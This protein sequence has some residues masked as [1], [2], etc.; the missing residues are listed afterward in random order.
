M[1][2]LPIN[3]E[4]DFSLQNLPYGVF[5]PGPG[6]A[7]R[8]GVAVGNKVMDLS[9]LAEE[10]VFGDSDNYVSCFS[11][12]YLN[13]FMAMGKSA[14]VSVRKTLQKLLSEDIAELRDN[15]ELKAKVF[16]SL[17]SVTMELPAKIGDY[18]DF[19]SSRE[20]A[21][22]V[23][24]MFRGK[25]N[26]LQPNWLHLPV[27]YHGRASSVVVSGTSIRRPC[28]QLQ[29]NMK[30]PKEGSKYGVSERLDIELE[31]G[32]LIGPGNELGTP[33][34]I[35][36]AEDHIFGFV[37]LN[38]W[39]ARDIQK[40]EYV[41]L[42]PFGAKNFGTTIS[43]WVV[44]PMALEPFKCKTSAGVQN[45][46][47]PLPYLVEPDYRSYDI[48]LRVTIQADDIP[49]PVQVSRSNFKNMYWTHRQQLV[50]HT[51]TGCNMKPG[52]LLGS[53][54][55]SG[56]TEDSYGSFLELSWNKQ[57]QV[58]CGESAT[59]YFLEDGDVISITGTCYGD[60]YRIGFGDCIGKILPAQSKYI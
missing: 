45:D 50:H 12:P 40:W 3:P 47:E 57:K 22:N 59:R 51:V 4:S 55:I 11:K 15:E 1:S 30:D 39:S 33:I 38:D 36:D 23:G 17:D 53:G 52:D 14:W 29:K 19:Y 37:L 48:D 54:T 49:K 21:T 7:A 27:G 16:H 34:D 32:V 58:Q 35:K 46:P 25:E 8:V 18:T 20:H 10:G 42:G 56:Q 41:P 28:G 26:A 24:I 44:T 43:P 6:A 60:G 31:M 13:D 9:A 5:R 2:W